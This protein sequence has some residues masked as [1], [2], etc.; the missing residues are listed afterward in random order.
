MQGLFWRIS[1]ESAGF[2]PNM[3]ADSLPPQ[4]VHRLQPENAAGFQLFG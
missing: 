2:P 4:L 3:G 1:L